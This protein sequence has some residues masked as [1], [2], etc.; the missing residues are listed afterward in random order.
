MSSIINAFQSELDT[1]G[2]I[3][4]VIRI[5]QVAA[6]TL[7]LYEH[8]ITLD[9][10]IKYIWK[11]FCLATFLYIII[12]YVGDIVAITSIIALM[13]PPKSEEFCKVVI[14]VQGWL[15]LILLFPTQAVL[16][17]RIYALCRRSRKILSLMLVFYVAEMI[18]LVALVVVITQDVELLQVPFLDIALC[19]GPRASTFSIGVT[20]SIL[21]FEGLLFIILLWVVIRDSLT[22]R[23]FFGRR[24]FEA[25]VRGNVFYFVCVL[26]ICLFDVIVLK[27]LGE[28]WLQLT[29]SI[30]DAVEVT[31]G[32]RLI[33]NLHASIFR[34]APPELDAGSDV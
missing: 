27:T 34:D 4:W 7:V 5:C 3:I 9:Q 19:S 21:S 12:R 30:S 2:Y 13:V 1:A 10:E 31:V 11:K 20:I 8:V 23:G 29:A 15:P 17:I 26:A 14:S 33:L 32:C 25:L 28:D 16:Q 18:T 6:S 22:S 24:V